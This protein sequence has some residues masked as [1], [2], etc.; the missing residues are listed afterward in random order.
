M[1][2]VNAAG[3]T[4][5]G[6][7]IIGGG[8]SS[9]T[10]QN[11]GT[12]TA[13]GSAGMVFAPAATLVNTGLIQAAGGPLTF[14]NGA[15]NTGG[16]IRADGSSVT[17]LGGRRHGRNPGRHQRRQHGVELDLSRAPLCKSPPAPARPSRQRLTP[18]AASTYRAP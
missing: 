18:G 10:F 6:A 2:L 17:F 13:S 5:A 15:T 1:T 11:A 12:V 16:I 14:V 7:G 4:I 8:G 3:H 9:F